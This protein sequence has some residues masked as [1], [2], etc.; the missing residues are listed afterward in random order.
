[1]SVEKKKEY[2][3]VLYDFLLVWLTYN[4]KNIYYIS[5]IYE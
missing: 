4:I 1:M 2:D 3:S 5:C